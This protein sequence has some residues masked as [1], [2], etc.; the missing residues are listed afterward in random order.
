M[1]RYKY[2]RLAGLIGCHFMISP[3]ES[4]AIIERRDVDKIR[5]AWKNYNRYKGEVWDWPEV[6]KVIRQGACNL[7]RMI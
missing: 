6:S 3:H 4:I 5:K 1:S 2:R 7:A